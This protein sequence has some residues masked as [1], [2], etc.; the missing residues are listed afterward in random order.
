MIFSTLHIWNQ[1]V[2][3]VLEHEGD[4]LVWRQGAKILP[5][6][7]SC[8]DF[9]AD[10]MSCPEGPR[11]RVRLQIRNQ[12]TWLTESKCCLRSN[13]MFRAAEVR[14]DPLGRVLFG[15]TRGLAP[16][17]PG[18]L[19]AWPLLESGWINLDA[20]GDHRNNMKV[21]MDNIPAC[22][23]LQTPTSG[24]WANAIGVCAALGPRGETWLTLTDSEEGHLWVVSWTEEAGFEIV[25][26]FQLPKD[27]RGDAIGA[28][29]GI[30]I[31]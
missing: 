6:H 9:W 7:K 14:T 20:S 5:E 25:Q 26:D 11:M 2:V 19:C 31:M 13:W 10:G 18:Y 16:T 27:G 3:D 28:S 24:G 8:S 23:T 17:E 4:D 21:S 30:W 12:L 22:H 1:K 29:V 15:S